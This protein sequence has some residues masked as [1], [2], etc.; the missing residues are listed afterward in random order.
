M[1]FLTTKIPVE[2]LPPFLWIKNTLEIHNSIKLKA[3]TRI[4]NSDRKLKS[5]ART[6]AANR[7]TR[8]SSSV[9][10]LEPQAR[11]VKLESQAQMHAEIAR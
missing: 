9:L 2:D 1:G 10:K 8:I 7:Q 4:A 6:K 3:Q 11:I 5:Q